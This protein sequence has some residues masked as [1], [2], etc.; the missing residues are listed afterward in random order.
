[1]PPGI[2]TFLLSQID[3]FRRFHSILVMRPY[4]GI[5]PS[6]SNVAAVTISQQFESI[7]HTAR[8]ILP[9]IKPSGS[10]CLQYSSQFGHAAT[11]I[12]SRILSPSSQDFSRFSQ[13]GHTVTRILPR[14]EPP[15][16]WHLRYFS[17][18]GHAATRILP[19]IKLSQPWYLRYF[20]QCGHIVTKFQ[21]LVTAVTGSQSFQANRGISVFRS[22]RA[23]DDI[24]VNG[25]F[26]SSFGSWEL[27][28]ARAR[29]YA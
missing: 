15:Q 26:K 2:R 11:R 20:S 28:S 8:R 1:M 21:P 17:Q 29:E 13:F 14:M 5:I 12:L 22:L 10:R 19:R 24:I 4:I 25:L 23:S 27:S 3:C 16:L 6:Q 18:F 9:R 7:N